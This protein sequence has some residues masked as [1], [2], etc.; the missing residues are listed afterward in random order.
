[1]L[2]LYRNVLSV[3]KVADLGHV[4]L[5]DKTSC[6][7]FTKDK[8]FRVIAQGKRVPGSGLYKL[9]QLSRNLDH[10]SQQ[11]HSLDNISR[12]HNPQRLNSS[13]ESLSQL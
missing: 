13:A 8:P 1:M 11:V 9:I 2:G 5:F 7:V 3:G 10:T 12:S 4:A 6:V